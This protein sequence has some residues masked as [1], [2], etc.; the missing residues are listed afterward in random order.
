MKRSICLFLCA[1]ALL[2]LVGCTVTKGE[3]TFTDIPFKSAS[4]QLVALEG[5]EQTYQN[6]YFFFTSAKELEKG[7]DALAQLFDLSAAAEG[8]QS[9]TD[10]VQKYDDSFFEEN[11]LL[12]IKR[13]HSTQAV[14]QL[15]SLEATNNAFTVH[16]QLEGGA[17]SADLYRVYLLAFSKNYFLSTEPTIDVQ[18]EAVEP[19]TENE[20]QQVTVSMGNTYKVV[21]DEA[22]GQQ[23][24]EMI[25][26]L[27]LVESD[28]DPDAHTYGVSDVSVV[29]PGFFATFNSDYIG[30]GSEVYA[31]DA[32]IKA[33]LVSVYNALEGDT[34]AMET[35]PEEEDPSA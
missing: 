28:Y 10:V 34:N 29:A 5:V 25:R 24:L 8:A 12:F 30:I 19:S 4:A 23:L 21:E 1:V 11:V 17:D 16:A 32:E 15:N 27:P 20:L 35:Q 13:Y 3:R 7:K 2:F 18:T 22:Y 31:P 26:A 14:L 33:R 6:E 9:F